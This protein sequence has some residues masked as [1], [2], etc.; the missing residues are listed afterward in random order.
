M[1]FTLIGNAQVLAP[2]GIKVGNTT[3][4]PSE[5]SFLHGL[6]GTITTTFNKVSDNVNGYTAV[7]SVIDSL[8]AG[9]Y[10]KG[11]YRYRMQRDSIAAPNWSG[12]KTG[13]VAAWEL[14]ETSGTTAAN[15]VSGAPAG[16]VV[17]DVTVNQTGMVSKYYQFGGTNGAIDCTN[18]SIFDFVLS[19]MS[20]FCWVKITNTSTYREIFRR[21]SYMDFL[22]DDSNVLNLYLAGTVVYSS[23]LSINTWHSIGFTFN[24]TTNA[25]IIYVDGVSSGTGT[26]TTPLSS[27]TNTMQLGL[28][29]SNTRPYLGGFDQPIF[30]NLVL[31]PTKITT[32]YNSRSG[33]PIS[34]M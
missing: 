31:T 34:G 6:T 5:L 23:A 15:S 12:L 22:I 20:F 32:L 1:A 26:A 9:T 17:G 2:K 19:D 11:S 13:M 16:T 27:N 24:H 29:L 8:I 14:N 28:T 30:W 4:T 18:S 3:V 7:H 10:V 25:I 33:L 21:A